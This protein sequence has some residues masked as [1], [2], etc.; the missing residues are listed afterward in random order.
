MFNRSWNFEKYPI[1]EKIGSLKYFFGVSKYF[2]MEGEISN[3]RCY[4]DNQISYKSSNWTKECGYIRPLNG[5]SSTRDNI[6][7]DLIVLPNPFDS[8]I[9][10]FNGNQIEYELYDSFGR[11]LLK[12]K[13]SIVNTAS[14]QDGIYFLKFTY[15]KRTTKTIKLIKHLNK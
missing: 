8:F 6:T 7:N 3:L 10:I 9:Q 12:G 5:P 1:V 2:V 4:T 13:D 15:D 11:L 14:L